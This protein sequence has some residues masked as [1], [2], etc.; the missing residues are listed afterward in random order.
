MGMDLELTEEQRIL[1]E[2]VRNFAER[3][4]APIADEIDREERFPRE[5]F[6]KMAEMG[7]LGMLIP[8]AYGGRG[9]SKDHI[10]HLGKEC[11]GTFYRREPK[12]TW[13][14]RFSYRR[15]DKF[16][17]PISNFQLIKE[18]LAEMAMEIEAARILTMKAA[19]LLQQGKKATKECSFA[20]L[21]GSRISVKT[22]LNAVQILGGYGY[23]KEFPAERY[24]RDAKL[25][26]IG[27]GTSE[28]QKLIIAS[29]I[30][31]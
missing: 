24:L 29:E 12:K 17:R 25:L 16:G 9:A 18:L 22:A 26:E 31:K 7:L 4:L 2:T 15:I 13:D 6:H 20:K 21:F 28:I 27:G 3:E 11:R 19:F 5:S 8:Q 14:E 1:K 30:L 23:T 10:L